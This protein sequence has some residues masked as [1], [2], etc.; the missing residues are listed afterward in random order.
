MIRLRRGSVNFQLR[1]LAVA[2]RH[3]GHAPR[4]RRQFALDPC[5]IRKRPVI[6][7]ARI[8]SPHIRRSQNVDLMTNMVKR[9]QAIEEHQHAIWNIQIILRPVANLFQLPND[10]IREKSNRSRGKRRQSGGRRC[11]M[12]TQQGLHVLEHTAGMR[13]RTLPCLHANLGS[14][15]RKLLMRTHPQKGIAPNLLAAFHRFQQERLRLIRGNR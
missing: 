5:N 11:P 13:Y 9:Q 8:F 14:P 10:V 3:P 7:L 15:R 2:P 6:S 4:P 12:L 1:G